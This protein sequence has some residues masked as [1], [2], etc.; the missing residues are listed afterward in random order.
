MR[1]NHKC[2]EVFK[3]NAGYSCRF[4]RNL[5]FLKR[6]SKN[7]EISNFM[8][9]RLVEAELSHEDRRTDGQTDMTKLTVA[10]RNFAN[11]PKNP[12]SVPKE[13]PVNRLYMDLY[14]AT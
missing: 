1:Y 10:V 8:E 11:A 6:F 4:S 9:I 7:A 3:Q 2:T 12:C 5:S 14:S 13:D